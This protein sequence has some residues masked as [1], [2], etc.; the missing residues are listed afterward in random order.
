MLQLHQKKTRRII[1]KVVVQRE[2]ESH[3]LSCV[4]YIALLSLHFTIY[5]VY[6]LRFIEWLIVSLS[7]PHLLATAGTLPKIMVLILFF[8]IKKQINFDFTT[9]SRFIIIY[10][11]QF[12]YRMY[13]DHPFFKKKLKLTFSFLFDLD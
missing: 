8:I 12:Y 4:L 2:V 3:I 11:N 7:K 1:T 6:I 9:T 13:K 10:K 5:V